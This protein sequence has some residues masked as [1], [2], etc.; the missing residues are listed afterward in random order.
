MRAIPSQNSSRLSLGTLMALCITH[1]VP[2]SYK[3]FGLGMSSRGSSWEI[4][5]NRRFSPKDCTSATEVGRPTVIGRSAPGKMI[6]SR[7][8]RTGTSSISAGST[9]STG[10]AGSCSSTAIAATYHQCSVHNALAPSGALGIASQH[11]QEVRQLPQMVEGVL[12]VGA[13]HSPEKVYIEQIFPGL[14][15][16]GAGLD[17]GQAE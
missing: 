2:I 17:L 4:T 8:A 16:Q 9:I 12:R 10:C 15:T 5:A 14:A 13:V 7:T 6:V 11:P 1:S 3:S